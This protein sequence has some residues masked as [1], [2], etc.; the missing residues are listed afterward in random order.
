M[1]ATTKELKTISGEKIKITENKAKRTVTIRTKHHKYRTLPFN[2]EDFNNQWYWSGN[3][4]K[5]F[6]KGNDY[7]VVR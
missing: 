5:D 6:L 7:Y 3:D 2:K 4:W 1:G